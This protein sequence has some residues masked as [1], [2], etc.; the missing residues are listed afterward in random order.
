M[1]I[2]TIC[3]QCKQ[4][5]LTQQEIN[6]HRSKHYEEQLKETHA[7]AAILRLNYK[8]K[9]TP[10]ERQDELNFIE[11]DGCHQKVLLNTVIIIEGVYC[12]NCVMKEE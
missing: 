1:K 6:E 7:T 8:V 3:P 11:C 10:R 5:L 4:K 12:E 2:L 9:K